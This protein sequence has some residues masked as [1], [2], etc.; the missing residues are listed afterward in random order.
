M[1]THAFSSGSLVSGRA[2]G[3]AENC[4][5]GFGEI[6]VKVLK[7]ICWRFVLCSRDI[8]PASSELKSL[9]CL[10]LNRGGGKEGRYHHQAFL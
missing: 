9:S 8:L 6:W 3:V 7:G 10:F 5:A 2:F 4:Q 1:Q